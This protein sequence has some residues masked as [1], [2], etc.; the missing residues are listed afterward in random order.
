MPELFL[1]RTEFP[2]KLFCLLCLFCVL[3]GLS[4]F[5]KTFSQQNFCEAEEAKAEI[6]MELSTGR[7]LAGSHY[8]EK[9]P[10]AST[11]KIMTAILVIED[12]DLTETISV[13]REAVGIEG[14]SVYLKEG[15]KITI[16]DLLY[17]LMLRSG[18]DCSVALAIAHSGSVQAFVQEMNARALAYG[19]ENTHFTNPNGLPDAEHFTTARDLCNIARHAMQNETFQKI[20]S[21]QSYEGDY[22]N[23]TNKN[24]LLKTYEG[25][26]GVKTGYT[27]KAGRCLV[28]SAKRGEMDVVTVVLNCPAMY[29]RSAELLDACF[30]NYE[31]V[32]LNQEQVFFCNGVAS[33]LNK[34]Q[35]LVANKTSGWRVEVVS[36][37]KFHGVQKGD[38]IGKLHIFEGN[39]LLFSENLYS[40]ITVK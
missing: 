18:N 28:A 6:A 8:D 40:I 35:Q 5:N 10:M 38:I 29:E 24:K 3:M 2:R 17:G 7:I 19:A 13:P 31:L 32:T 4:Q 26:N 36:E 11:T 30:A 22:R 12:C 16:R 1:K 9:L 20:V 21:T 33:T 34:T 25:A 27:L 39:S 37:N 15:E 14:S 23:F